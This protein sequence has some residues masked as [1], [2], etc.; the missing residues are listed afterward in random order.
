MRWLSPQSKRRA[1]GRAVDDLVGIADKA[2]QRSVRPGSRCQGS[3]DPAVA[4]IQP[5]EGIRPR[6]AGGIALRHNGARGFS[7][8]VR[9]RSASASARGHVAF[10]GAQ[11]AS[12]DPA[13]I[14]Q[15]A[16]LIRCPHPTAPTR[17]ADDCPCGVSRPDYALEQHGRCRS[18][19]GQGDGRFALDLDDGFARQEALPAVRRA[20]VLRDPAGSVP[21]YKFWSS[22]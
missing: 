5:G 20:V 10:G 7:A 2:A 15:V 6:L 16:A 11:R 22:R 17:Q 21:R 3:A 8:S 13:S 4:A 1:A 18:A 19:Q 9:G 14:S 12:T